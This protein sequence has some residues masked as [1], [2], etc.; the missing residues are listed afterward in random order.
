M[1]RLV[2]LSFLLM[3]M[4]CAFS[5][6]TVTPPR[7]AISSGIKG[8]QGRELVV[9]APFSDERPIRNRCGMQKNGFNMDT[10]NAYCAQEP[11]VYL[12]ELLANELKE[13]GFAVTLQPQGA[14]PLKLEGKLLQF[15]VEPK[16]GFF[17][18]TPE[19]DIQIR[20]IVVSSSGLSAERDFYVK[21]EETSMI[22]WQENFQLATE[23]ATRRIIK[24]MA[25]AIVALCD[26]FPGVG[27]P[28]PKSVQVSL[29]TIGGQGG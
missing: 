22:G 12:A 8:G 17:T 10:A 18:F 19:A 1:S 3:G 5:N 9:Q 16:V 23:E 13:A 27:A 14:D 25:A 29:R 2:V 26:R 21:A 24:E 4:G 20:L 7:G 15:F 28:P 11:S 6:A